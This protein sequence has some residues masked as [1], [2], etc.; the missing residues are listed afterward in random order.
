MGDPDETRPKTILMDL[1][2]DFDS[3]VQEEELNS[4]LPE[5]DDVLELFPEIADVVLWASNH[6]VSSPPPSP[7]PSPRPPPPPPPSPP[8]CHYPAPP[9]TGLQSDSVLFLMPEGNNFFHLFGER[10][11]DGVVAAMPSEAVEPVPVPK[12]RKHEED[13]RTYIKKPPN[14]FML[15]LKSQRKTVQ[16]ELG[17]KNSAVVNK[18]LSERWKSLPAEQRDVFKAEAEAKAKIHALNN[19][20]W[21]NKVNYGKKSK[22]SNAKAP[23]LPPPSC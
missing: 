14:A 22:K 11:C 21:S 23:P 13:K 19:P 17:I 8:L 15:F 16:E 12:K 7:P 4:L 9:P 3:F 20:G 6:M 2:D 10:D 1:L 18:V 5:V